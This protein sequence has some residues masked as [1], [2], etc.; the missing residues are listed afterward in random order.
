MAYSEP[1][2]AESTDEEQTEVRRKYVA[3]LIE[4]LEFADTDQRTET[5]IDAIELRLE[6]GDEFWVNLP[7]EAVRALLKGSHTVLKKQMNRRRKIGKYGGQ[8]ADAYHEV[9]NDY[10]RD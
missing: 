5:A 4:L 1:N 8:L 6:D 9:E 7:A 3:E 10:L 2:S